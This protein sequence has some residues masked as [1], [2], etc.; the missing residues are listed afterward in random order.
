MKCKF[1]GRVGTC[2]TEKN[3]STSKI[4]QMYI[5]LYA[6][7]TWQLKLKTLSVK[8]LLSNCLWFSYSSTFHMFSI[9]KTMVHN[10]AE[11]FDPHLARFL[12][13]GIWLRND[14]NRVNFWTMVQLEF[15]TDSSVQ[16]P[17]WRFKVKLEKKWMH[18]KYEEVSNIFRPCN[19][20]QSYPVTMRM[21]GLLT[22]KIKTICY[23]HFANI[24]YQMRHYATLLICL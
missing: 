12:F 10:K 8:N 9:Y 13:R 14:E 2:Y 20:M 6:L 4:M 17:Q 15:M 7:V 24:I 19:A 3:S 5:A 22:N 18:K 16:E 11:F 21:K 1:L 23:L